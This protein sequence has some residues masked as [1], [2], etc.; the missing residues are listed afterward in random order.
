MDTQYRNDQRILGVSG[1][2]IE[3]VEKVGMVMHIQSNAKLVG[4]K[5][6]GELYHIH[7]IMRS[8]EIIAHVDTREVYQPTGQSIREAYW[9]TL[10]FANFQQEDQEII[11][12]EFGEYYNILRRPFIFIER[13]ESQMLKYL[14]ALAVIVFMA[15]HAC[16]Q[17]GNH[18]SGSRQAFTDRCSQMGLRRM[19]RT[20]TGYIGLAVHA[21]QVGDYVC[22]LKSARTPFLLRETYGELR[23]IGDSY[24][25]G[26]MYGERWL[27]DSCEILWLH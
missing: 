20:E 7:Q 21:A 6:L 17:F 19:I 10:L 12:T 1:H 4:I 3:R 13:L 11:R 16:R 25:H 15:I 22:L 8:W 24:I 9:Q 26:M 18:S 14:W 23:L 5:F 2:K 27:E